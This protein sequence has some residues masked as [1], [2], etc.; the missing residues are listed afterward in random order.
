[1]PNFRMIPKKESVLLP[2][3]VE[4]L[5]KRSEIKVIGKCEK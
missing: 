5:E 3:K 2:P 1:M 4:I